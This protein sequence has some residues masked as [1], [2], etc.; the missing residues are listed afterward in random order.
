MH[1]TL[2]LPPLRSLALSAFP[3]M[4]PLCPSHRTRHPN[5]SAPCLS[6]ARVCVPRL[7]ATLQTKNYPPRRCSNAN[8]S[9]RH[10]LI[11]LPRVRNTNTVLGQ[12]LVLRHCIRMYLFVHL[13]LCIYLTRQHQSVS[14]RRTQPVSVNPGIPD[15]GTAPGM[16]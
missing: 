2:C 11:T 13:H 6:H 3:T 1:L 15:S 10:S 5:S 12:L 14:Y 16:G 8:A 7:H 4:E 9:A